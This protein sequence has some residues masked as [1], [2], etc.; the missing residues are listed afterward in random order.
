MEKLHFN[1]QSSTNNKKAK[2]A[3]SS[4]LALLLWKNAVLQKRSLFGA[5]LELL[6]PAVF[7][8]ILLPIRTIV[9]SNQKANFTTY[10]SFGLN[11]FDIPFLFRN[12]SFGVSPNNSPLVNNI[13][14]RV[15]N[16]FNLKY[17]TFAEE[18]EMVKH[19]TKNNE[20]FLFAAAFLNESINYF[21]YKLRFSYAPRNPRSR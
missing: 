1:A 12:F 5:L 7:V 13:T 17:L 16:Q 2:K 20:N 14:N 10:N 21:T 19:V 9:E 11:M 8:L 18:N 15:A 6:I 4:Q 3:S